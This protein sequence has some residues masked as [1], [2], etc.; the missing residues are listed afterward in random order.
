MKHLYA[1]WRENYTTSIAHTKNERAPESECIFC[2]LFKEHAD[3]KNFILR[4]LE[5]TIV[6]FNRFPYNA[7]HLLI[8]PIEHKASLND[9]TKETRA[10]IMEIT[11]QSIEILKKNLECDGVNVGLNLGKAA[12]A[13]IP[14]HLHMHVLPRF[15]GDTNFLP[16]IA[17]TK[18]I[19]FDLYELFKQLKPEFDKI[20]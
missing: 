11:S 13:G 2:K 14:S 9:L 20:G 10:E 18:A 6:M 8:L 1:P 5:H 12:G 3:E 19:S 17:D 4:R 7:G 15:T 16:T